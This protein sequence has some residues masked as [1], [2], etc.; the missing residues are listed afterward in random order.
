MCHSWAIQIGLG[1]TLAGVAIRQE[2]RRRSCA[3][4]SPRVAAP[5]RARRESHG[6]AC[7]GG[8][9][10][11]YPH[12]ELAGVSRR[13]GRRSLVEVNEQDG[14]LLRFLL[15]EGDELGDG[16]HDCCACT[17]KTR[18]GWVCWEIDREEETDQLIG[19]STL[20]AMLLIGLH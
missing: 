15:Q 3:S 20:R 13:G 11:R 5:R 12:G 10:R 18:P 14:A 4:G 7:G 6:R 9:H 2:G 17:W 8:G 1:V 16:S 19:N